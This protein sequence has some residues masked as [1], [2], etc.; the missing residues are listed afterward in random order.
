MNNKA[1]PIVILILL[2]LFSACSTYQLGSGSKL[3]FKNIYIS[4]L[5]NQTQAPQVK[6]LIS[7]I[8]R[9][10]FVNDPRLK[11]VSTEQQ[12]DVILNLALSGFERDMSAR[13]EDSDLAQ[14][15]KMGMQLKCT[16]VDADSGRIYFRDRM[17]H[18]RVIAY[19]DQHI[20]RAQSQNFP[21]L[22]ED[23]AKKVLDEVTGVW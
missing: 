8:V 13:A 21:S 7:T 18:S 10:K 17:I 23:L 6:S 16:L 1:L 9:Q 11:V 15:Y 5:E 3:P 22:A 2:A 20:S 12:A 19:N 4:A 14:S